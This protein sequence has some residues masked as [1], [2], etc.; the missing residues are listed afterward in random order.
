MPKGRK[1][2][3]ITHGDWRGRLTRPFED[4]F[5]DIFINGEYDG[6]ET[7]LRNALAYVADVLDL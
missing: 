7:T 1:T 3:N 5:W 2:V 6:Y 4:A